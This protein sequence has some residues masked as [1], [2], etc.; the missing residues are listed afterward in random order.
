MVATRPEAAPL[1]FYHRTGGQELFCLLRGPR[2]ARKA[3][4]FVPPFLE[5]MNRCRRLMTETALLLDTHGVGSLLFDLPGTG[6]SSGDLEHQ[7]W[8]SW[9]RTVD[10]MS[11]LAQQMFG[12]QP[13]IVAIRAGALL[14]H[15]SIFAAKQ[16]LVLAAP[17]L[18]GAQQIR[19]WARSAAASAREMGQSLDAKTVEVN[20]SSGAPILVSGYEVPGDIVQPMAA[21]D[22]S[23]PE[24]WRTR[25]DIHIL[26]I[27][28]AAGNAG[29]PDAR[30]HAVAGPS[31]WAQVEP[32]SA[33]AWARAIADAVEAT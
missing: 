10:S 24:K 30:L 23:T 26:Q 17:L 18:N 13:I 2:P 3:V 4:L 12:V 27:Q 33:T 19:L 20:A 21:I 1:A 15:D 14:L 8:D 9:T 28:G 25:T 31:V 5:E 16:P 22:L 29:M 6:D 32:E 11:Q 7:T